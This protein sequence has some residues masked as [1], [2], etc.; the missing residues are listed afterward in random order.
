MYK[1]SKIAQKNIIDTP[2]VKHPTA[3]Q[4]LKRSPVSSI[5]LVVTTCHQMNKKRKMYRQGS[6]WTLTCLSIL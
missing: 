4:G 2:I 1:I 3:T 6:T 5:T